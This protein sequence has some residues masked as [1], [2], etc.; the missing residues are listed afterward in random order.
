MTYDQNLQDQTTKRTSVHN[1]D[2]IKQS[3][4]YKVDHHLD[5][6]VNLAQKDPLA[7][8]ETVLAHHAWSTE[9]KKENNTLEEYLKSI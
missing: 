2:L 8:I 3:K 9:S 6:N 4:K 7:F 1:P 5:T